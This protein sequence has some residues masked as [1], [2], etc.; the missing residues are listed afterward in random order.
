MPDTTRP[1]VWQSVH[2]QF[3]H[4]RC[5]PGARSL[6]LQSGWVNST[7]QPSMKPLHS[8]CHPGRFGNCPWLFGRGWNSEHSSSFFFLC[9]GPFLAVWFLNAHKRLKKKPVVL[10]SSYQNIKKK[11][12][13]NICTLLTL[14]NEISQRVL[15]VLFGHGD[16]FILLYN[17]ISDYNPLEGKDSNVFIT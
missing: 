8:N 16:C 11:K 2:H 17:N 1:E 10:K 15:W 6:V 14:N 3:K 7:Q 13:V 4:R 5:S 9:C 12:K